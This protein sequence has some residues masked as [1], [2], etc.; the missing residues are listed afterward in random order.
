MLNAVV[1]VAGPFINERLSVTDLITAEG[2]F[3]NN[4]SGAVTNVEFFLLQS[5]SFFYTV[6][7]TQP[8]I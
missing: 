5:H 1:S 7:L 2:A 6:D 3:V 8:I 4:T